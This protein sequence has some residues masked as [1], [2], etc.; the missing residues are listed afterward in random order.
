M[1]EFAI[2][3]PGYTF[4]MFWIAVWGVVAVSANIRKMVTKSPDKLKVTDDV[5][6]EES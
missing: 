3:N 2:R 4:L 6:E 1:A 5:I